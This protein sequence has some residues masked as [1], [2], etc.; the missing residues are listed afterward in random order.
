MKLDVRRPILDS[1]ISFPFFTE[2]SPDLELT[3]LPIKQ[4]LMI[5]SLTVKLS[6]QNVDRWLAFSAVI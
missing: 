6:K 2:S 3:Q 1:N 4:A 5:S